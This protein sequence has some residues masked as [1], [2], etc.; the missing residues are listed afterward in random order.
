MA[1]YAKKIFEDISKAS[2]DW[3]CYCISS[4][5]WGYVTHDVSR[6]LA[7]LRKKYV[8]EIPIIRDLA[9]EAVDRDIQSYKENK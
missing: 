1:E 6:T 7:E 8:V 2:A 3:G 5:K 9:E 4:T